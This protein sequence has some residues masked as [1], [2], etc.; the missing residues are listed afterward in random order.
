MRFRER[1]TESAAILAARY[2]E[3]FKRVEEQ[4]I[5]VLTREA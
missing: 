1:S 2:L 4:V 3:E 5:E